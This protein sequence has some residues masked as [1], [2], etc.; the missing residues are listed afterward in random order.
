MVFCLCA[1]P[2]TPPG[3]AE[4]EGAGGIWT[5]PFEAGGMSG[6]SIAPGRSSSISLEPA[7][8]AARVGREAKPTSM[9]TMST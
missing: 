1:C 9:A 8:M 3:P 6:T 7:V 2:R 5:G 4:A